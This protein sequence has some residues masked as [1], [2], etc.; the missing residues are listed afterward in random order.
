MAKKKKKKQ[1]VNV[2]LNV[3]TLPTVVSCVTLLTLAA[4]P[5]THTSIHTSDATL[6]SCS[7]E[8]KKHCKLMKIHADD[9]VYKSFC[10]LLKL[11]DDL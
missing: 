7:A 1:D 6:L 9:A 4:I 11:H 10:T 3:L 8:K 5:L 2:S